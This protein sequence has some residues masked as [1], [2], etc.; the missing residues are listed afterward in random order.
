MVIVRTFA[1]M[2]YKRYLNLLPIVI[3][4]F[5]LLNNGCRKE[6]FF[7]GPAT[8]SFDTDTV[9]FDTVFT[10][11][12]NTNGPRSLNKQLVV[13]NMEKKSVKTTIRLAGGTSSPFRINIDGISTTQINDYEIRGG[14]SIF[15]FVECILEANNL[16]NPAIIIDSIVFNTQG[17]ISDIKLA[18]YGWD[19]YYF[20]DSI[21]PCNSIWDKIDKPYVIISS[22]LV[23]KNC[24]LQIEK[25]VHIYADPYSNIYVLGTI[26]V[27]GEKD[28]EVIFQG[29]RLQYEYREQPG[30][31]QGIHLLRGSLNNKINYAVI[32]NASVGIRIDS[33]PENTN[34]G[35]E[36]NNTI[37]RNMSSFGI[38]G[39]TAEIVATNCLIHSCGLYNVALVYG[40]K[41]DFRH[42]TIFG[43]ATK[44]T[45]HT[46]PVLVLN[47]FRSE[48]G[49]VTNTYDMAYTFVNNIIYGS[50]E[51]EV[52]LAF[53]NTRPPTISIFEKNL[54]KVKKPENYNPNNNII[55]IDPA[56]VNITNRNFMLSV[57]SPAINKGISGIGVLLDLNNKARDATPDIGAYEF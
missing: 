41:Y 20:R 28:N 54:I 23:N 13:R 9:Y 47:N 51:N 19:A 25:G 15:I 44:Y 7:N 32:K 17:K 42:C 46:E 12:P 29:D 16:L 38:I 22:I 26:E 49:V 24:K 35:L 4:L 14:D 2:P 40:G 6:K 11:I 57:G 53:I 18:A 48:N 21:L 8:L 30:Q 45:N 50:I 27:N 43:S 34:P 31:W 52:S 56:F 55:N 10:R 39:Y 36:I 1:I 33:L 5:V 37:I 3:T